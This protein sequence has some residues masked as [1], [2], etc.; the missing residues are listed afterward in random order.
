[1]T[2]ETGSELALSGRSELARELATLDRRVRERL[3]LRDGLIVAI[4]LII[5]ATRI[6][7][8]D[9]DPRP[10]HERFDTLEP[11]VRSAIP[12]QEGLKAGLDAV[13]ED[14]PGLGKRLQRDDAQRFI[15]RLVGEATFNR[16]KSALRSDGAAL[17]V[18]MRRGVRALMPLALALDDCI[19]FLSPGQLSTINGFGDLGDSML[20]AALLLD[21][22]LEKGFDLGLPLRDLTVRDGE[23][24]PL[25]EDVAGNLENIADRLREVIEGETSELLSELSD[26][27]ARKIR[28]ARDVL[29]VS[30]DGVSQASSSLIELIDRLFRQVFTDDE[31]LEW[32]GRNRPNQGDLTYLDGSDRPRPTKRAQALM[33]AFGGQHG[34]D[35]QVFSELAAAGVVAARTELQRLK[36]AD[37]GSTQESR[38]VRQLIA[39]VEGYVV[40]SIRVG[41]VG[42]SQDGLVRLRARLGDLPA[43]P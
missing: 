36:H 3:G 20:K 11:V 15:H 33:F 6:L 25:V 43:G 14:L 40:F 29:E 22:A 38:T 39:A 1:M 8:D 13:A 32:V 35:G 12:D 9:E 27:L 23:L 28:G 26:R 18:A 31:V 41:W 24:E 34:A 7:I 2:Q 16:L 5:A 10:W 4:D 21:V 30:A 17:L 42:L 37:E 19:A